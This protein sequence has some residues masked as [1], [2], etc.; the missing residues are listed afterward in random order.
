MQRK[1]ASVRT[2]GAENLKSPV[3]CSQQE[4]VAKGPDIIK[5][6]LKELALERKEFISDVFFFCFFLGSM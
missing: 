2:N 6:E 5:G 1:A 3:Y 4:G